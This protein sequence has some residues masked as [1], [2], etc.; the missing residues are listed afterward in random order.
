MKTMSTGSRYLAAC[1]LA[2]GLGACFAAPLLVDQQAQRQQ[3]QRAACL[4]GSSGQEPRSCLK[5][6]V[7]AR[8]AARKGELD[9][10][11]SP[12]ALRANALKR[13]QLLGVEDKPACEA[14]ARHEGEASGSVRGGGQLRQITVR[15]TAPPSPAAASS[16]K[17]P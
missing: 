12:A 13:C 7:A 1:G 9:N 11:E 8:A 3:E 6:M 4:D 2:L 17:A 10:G 5:E 14:L 16:A 15:Q